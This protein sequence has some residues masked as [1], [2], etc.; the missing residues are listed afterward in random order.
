MN[1]R[2]RGDER[3]EEVQ[4]GFTEV[5]LNYIILLSHSPECHCSA[6]GNAHSKAV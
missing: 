5:T 3:V 6:I 1:E 2:G 4:W